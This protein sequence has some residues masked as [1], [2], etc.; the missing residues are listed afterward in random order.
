MERFKMLVER[1][2][3]G[4]MPKEDLLDHCTQALNAL[5]FNRNNTI[6]AVGLCRDELCRS[7]R[8]AVQ[9]RWGE[10]FDMSSLAG[11]LLLGRTGF[12]A[13]H[14]HAPLE[15]GKERYLYVAMPH[16]G[17]GPS[18]EVGKAFRLGRPGLSSACGALVAFRRELESGRVDPTLNQDDLEQSLIRIRL[19]KHLQFGHVPDL[20]ELTRATHDV[21]LEDLERT[22]ASTTDPASCDY[23][24][25]T[26][27]LLHAPNGRTW[28]WPGAVYAVVDG[29]RIDIACPPKPTSR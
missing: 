23:G 4:A 10:A 9:E 16:V 11:V 5:G 12:L 27:V 7:V 21:I 15:G 24:V 17:Y 8:H 13:A 29:K 14:D 26:G 2:F 6:P 20:V 28:I 3:P 22:V 1:D 19:L 25:V 18:G